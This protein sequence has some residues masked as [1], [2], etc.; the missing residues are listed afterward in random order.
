MTILCTFVDTGRSLDEHVLH[1]DQLRDVGFRRRIT[2]QLIGDDLAWHQVRAQL[3]LE[4]TFRRGFVTPLLQQDVEFDAVL[5]N[6]T[7]Q[8]IRFA[9]QGDEHLVEVPR[10]TRLAARRFHPMGK[11]RAELLAP[12]AIRLVADR[13]SALEQQLLNVAQAE[14]QPEVLTQ[15]MN[16]DRRREPVAVIKRFRSRHR[17]M[18]RKYP[19]N[20]TAPYP[21]G[22]YKK[23]WK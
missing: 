6:C 14:L 12:A 15:G 4:E 7:P 18:L 23:Y 2:A 10:A 20:V 11:A 16:D 22:H 1:V 9:T 21:H 5:V 17:I 19:A 8:Q 13:H 3:R